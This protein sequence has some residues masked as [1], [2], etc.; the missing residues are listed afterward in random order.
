M[1]RKCVVVGDSGVVTWAGPYKGQGLRPD[2]TLPGDC[3]LCSHDPPGTLV[4]C[5][6]SLVREAQMRC[7]EASRLTHVEPGPHLGFSAGTK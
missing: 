2:V 7:R 6:Y 1:P 4:G 3:C 5:L